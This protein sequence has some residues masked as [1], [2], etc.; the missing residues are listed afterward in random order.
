MRETVTSPLECDALLRGTLTSSLAA[1]W[2]D[3][4][5]RLI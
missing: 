5:N 4:P 1:L 3:C 2:N